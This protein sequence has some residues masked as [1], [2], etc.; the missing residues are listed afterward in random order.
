MSEELIMHTIDVAATVIAIAAI[1]F[2]IMK[3]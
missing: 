2:W 1:A 3:S